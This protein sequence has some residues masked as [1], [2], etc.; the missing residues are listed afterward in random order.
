MMYAHDEGKPYRVGGRAGY[1]LFQC[2]QVNITVMV[3]KLKFDNL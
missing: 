1:A 3:G 2:A